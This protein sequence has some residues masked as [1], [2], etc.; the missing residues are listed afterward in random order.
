MKTVIK[1][2]FKKQY[3]LKSLIANLQ[4]PNLL[5]R[6]TL[7][8]TNITTTLARIIVSSIV[9]LMLFNFAPITQAKTEIRFTPAEKFSIPDLKGV[10]GF[11]TNG[12]YSEAKLENNSWIFKD[13]KLDKTQ[14]ISDLG[15]D[16]VESIGDLKF[17]TEDSNVTIL[18][19]LSI[20]YSFPVEILSYSVEGQGKQTA[21]FSLDLSSQSEVSEWSVIVPDNIFLSEGQGWNFMYD[22]TIVV[23]ST[24]D[25]VTIAHFDFMNSVDSNVFFFLQ[26]SIALLTAII[27][28]IVVLAAIVIKVRTRKS[29][30]E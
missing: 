16:Y 22:G 3:L 12:S 28:V 11:G 18:A 29:K 14:I 6:G 4:Q 25:N 27:L 21:K 8:T 1:L 9:L 20:N 26:H 23:T 19:Y 30:T 10:I 17:S 5:C 24:A 13:L 7:K 2:D 15:F